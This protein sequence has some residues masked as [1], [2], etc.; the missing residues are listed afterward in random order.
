[1]SLM[2]AFGEKLQRLRL[3]AGLTPDGL[4]E[5]C[6]VPRETISKAEAGCLE[7]A[8]WLILIFCDGL[9]VSPNKLIGG[10]PV[11]QERRNHYQA[12]SS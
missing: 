12:G 10:L 7:P 4:A 3:A 9:G 5:A 1:M 6:R 11:P 8:L 2:R